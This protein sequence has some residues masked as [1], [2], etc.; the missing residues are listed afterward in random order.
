MN[1][2]QTIFKLLKVLAYD[3]ATDKRTLPVYVKAKLSSTPVV[4]L[5]ARIK[6]R[7]EIINRIHELR[8]EQ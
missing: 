8:D 4:E 1:V 5:K 7:G 6:L 3:Q 2:E